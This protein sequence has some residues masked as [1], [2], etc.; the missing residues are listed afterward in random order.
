MGFETFEFVVGAFDTEKFMAAMHVMLPKVMQPF[1]H[2]CSILVL[3]NCRTHHAEEAA[4]AGLISELGGKLL[5]LAPYCPIDSPIEFGFNCFKQYFRRHGAAL[6]AMDTHA[7]IETALRECYTDAPAS[8]ARTY[9][10]C[11]YNFS[12]R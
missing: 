1:P 3:D 5:Y 12:G 11:G 9:N 7:A 8:A 2:R 4:L 6:D 10:E